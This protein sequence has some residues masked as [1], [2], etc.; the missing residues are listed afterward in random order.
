[1][2]E[3]HQDNVALDLSSEPEHE[4][5]NHPKANSDTL[6]YLPRGFMEDVYTLFPCP[7]P[8]TPLKQKEIS[9][10]R[11]YGDITG[12]AKKLADLVS[13]HPTQFNKLLAKLEEL[14]SELSREILGEP[15]IKNPV[16]VPSKKRLRVSKE[17]GF[18]PHNKKHKKCSDLH[19][20]AKTGVKG[21]KR[22][23]PPPIQGTK[24]TKSKKNGPK[25]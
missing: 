11:R 2:Q 13:T 4:A 16:I 12:R 25:G 22:D 19:E 23:E 6:S 8:V 7:P 15:P 9:S 18:L 17:T 1:M 24:K 5:S 3:V 20:T 14:D 10:M 21:Q